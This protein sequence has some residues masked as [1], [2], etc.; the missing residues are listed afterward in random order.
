MWEKS[1][2]FT[3]ILELKKEH[4]LNTKEFLGLIIFEQIWNST[5]EI[6]TLTTESYEKFSYGIPII[7]FERLL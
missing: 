6:V 7:C 5:N 4:N 3:T 1:R 2:L